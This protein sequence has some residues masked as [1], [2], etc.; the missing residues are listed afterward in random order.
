M[1]FPYFSQIL[2]RSIRSF[3]YNKEEK[4]YELFEKDISLFNKMIE[5]I[6]KTSTNRAII[7]TCGHALYIWR[8]CQ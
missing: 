8:K 3:G 7:E 6:N 4:L 5:L 1:P 2:L